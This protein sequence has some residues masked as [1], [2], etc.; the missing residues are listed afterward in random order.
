MLNKKQFY[1]IIF[2]VKGDLFMSKKIKKNNDINN[3]K[4]YTNDTSK[5]SDKTEFS[6]EE[7]SK[8]LLPPTLKKKQKLIPPHHI[9]SS[10]LC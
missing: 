9:H 7:M 2:S 10:S 6:K 5:N 4:K 1:S 8:G 3:D